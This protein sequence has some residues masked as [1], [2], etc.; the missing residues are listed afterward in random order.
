MAFNLIL[1]ISIA[2]ILG[3][4]AL[5]IFAPHL[6][7]KYVSRSDGPPGTAD[8]GSSRAGSIT[9][10]VLFFLVVTYF[11][12]SGPSREVV[13]QKTANPRGEVTSVMAWIGLVCVSL[14]G[15]L[16][17]LFPANVIRRLLPVKIADS[18]ADAEALRTIKIFG[19]LLGILFLLGAVL[20]A[21]SLST[22]A[23]PVTRSSQ[24]RKDKSP[25]LTLAK[26]EGGKLSSK[27]R[28]VE[29]LAHPWSGRPY[30]EIALVQ[31]GQSL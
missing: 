22:D 5:R 6:Y 13:T 18:S 16:L 2:A 11:L 21:R 23:R 7:D 26:S 12:L 17:C 19:R 15:V 9:V 28:M 3:A 27:A 29:M 20:I 31:S 14:T 30:A 4:A 8:R 10:L 25:F 1:A 24:Q